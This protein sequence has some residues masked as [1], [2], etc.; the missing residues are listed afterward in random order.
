[1]PE[2]TF[3]ITVNVK[4]LLTSFI[5]KLAKKYVAM[6]GLAEELKGMDLTRNVA[7]SGEV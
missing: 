4:E 2:Q 7:V 5:P 3:T 1:M 6:A